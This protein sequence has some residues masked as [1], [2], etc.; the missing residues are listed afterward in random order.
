MWTAFVLLCSNLDPASC[1]STGGTA[2]PTEEQCV[3]D[4]QT[5]GMMFIARTYPNA[6][7]MGARCI[8]WGAQTSA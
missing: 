3:I 4:M 5:N 6:K 2:W 8:E 1:L 7:I